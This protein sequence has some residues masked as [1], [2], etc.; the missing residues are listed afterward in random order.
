MEHINGDDFSDFSDLSDVEEE[1]A[2]K[3]AKLDEWDSDANED[4]DCND[5]IEYIIFKGGCVTTKHGVGVVMEVTPEGD[6]TI[7]LYGSGDEVKIAKGD[8]GGWPCHRTT[9]PHQPMWSMYV[10]RYG[11]LIQG[12]TP[13]PIDLIE[14]ILEFVKDE[15]SF[16]YCT[17]RSIY[18]E[19]KGNEAAAEKWDANAETLEGDNIDLLEDYVAKHAEGAEPDELLDILEQLQEDLAPVPFYDEHFDA[20]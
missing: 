9:H 4:D 13:T 8:D 15:R 20:A 12:D 19:N 2:P 18:F 6:A 11:K 14:P 3:R 16:K 7:F 17:T 5:D 1:P 10:T